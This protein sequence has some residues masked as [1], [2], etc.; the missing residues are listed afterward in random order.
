M[1]DGQQ[2]TDLAQPIDVRGRPAYLVSVFGPHICAMAAHDPGGAMREIRRGIFL[3]LLI[4]LATALVVHA[5]EDDEPT[6][7][8]LQ[9]IEISQIITVVC[10]IISLAIYITGI[11]HLWRSAGWGHGISTRAAAAFGCGWVSLFIALIGPF[12][13]LSESLF[14]AHMTQHEILMLVSA[15]LIILGRPQIAAAWATP[16]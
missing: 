8:L 11:S 10:L 6:R 12:H 4:I 1:A 9:G 15:P 16:A 5:H 2:R 13:E 7:A 14:S 3:T